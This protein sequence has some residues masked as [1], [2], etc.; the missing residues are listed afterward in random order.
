MILTSNMSPIWSRRTS[1]PYILGQKPFRSK[2]IASMRTQRH[3]H[4]TD[5]SIEP[6]KWIA[7]YC[8]GYIS[9]RVNSVSQMISTNMTATD[10]LILGAWTKSVPGILQHECSSCHM[11][12]FTASA[13]SERA[14]RRSFS[15]AQ[16]RIFTDITTIDGG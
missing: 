7:E 5:C 14:H 3:T 11:E 6:L 10:S 4:R 13:V 2:V 15:H 9:A 1:M 16:P 12:Q 8:G